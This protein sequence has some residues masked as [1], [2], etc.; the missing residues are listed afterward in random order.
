MLVLRLGCRRMGTGL[1]FLLVGGALFC[2]CQSKKI[3]ADS[4]SDTAAAD[5]E[6]HEGHV[7][8]HA[9]FFAFHPTSAEADVQAVV[10][11]FRQLPT[12]IPEIMEFQSGINNSP[13]GRD[14]GF[15]HCFFLTFADEDGRSVYTPHPAH[16]GEFA[17]VLRPHMADV[18]VMD[19]W[20]TP[21][22]P[23]ERELKHAVF[24]KFRDDASPD[25]IHEVEE[26]FAAL[27][28]TLDLIQHFEWGINNSPEN[29]DDGFTHCFVLTFGSEADR[30]AYLTAPEHVAFVT[31]LKPV[32]DKARVL[33]FWGERSGGSE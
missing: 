9:V 6:N 17:D 26:A 3:P 16:A 1:I 4:S 27:P 15:T 20:G 25:Q 10:D 30:D 22:E 29:N 31:L 5:E 12:K 14:D 33:D 8:R 24:F 13:E 7:L 28:S 18:F 21:H 32:L 23:M 11:S 19:Y 2:S